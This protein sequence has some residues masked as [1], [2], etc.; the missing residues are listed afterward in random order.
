M[1]CAEAERRVEAQ[2]ASIEARLGEARRV[3]AAY[4]VDGAGNAG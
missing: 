4:E 2:L 3:L 1:I